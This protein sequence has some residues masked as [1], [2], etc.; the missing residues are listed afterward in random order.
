MIEKALMSQPGP[1]RQTGV[2]QAKEGKKGIQVHRP[3]CTKTERGEKGMHSESMKF[4]LAGLR[5][6]QRGTG[7]R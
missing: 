1:N 3:P 4:S 6:S 7:Q 2:S 5:S